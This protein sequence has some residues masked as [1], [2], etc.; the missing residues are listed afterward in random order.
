L[1]AFYSLSCLATR[2]FVVEQF[3]RTQ[4][5]TWFRGNEGLNPLVDESLVILAAGGL[6]FERLPAAT[7]AR[8]ALCDTMDENRVHRL[9]A[10]G[11]TERD[12]EELSKLH[13]P[14]FA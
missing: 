9:G 1:E 5:L 11:F 10:I 2:V 4:V 12:G 8:I 14:N 3:S 13:T 7:R 6:S